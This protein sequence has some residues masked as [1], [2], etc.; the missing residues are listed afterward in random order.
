[1]ESSFLNEQ[2]IIQTSSDILWIM[3]FTKNISMN[4]EQYIQ[5]TTI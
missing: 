2:G 1:M 3:Q 5:K 4:N